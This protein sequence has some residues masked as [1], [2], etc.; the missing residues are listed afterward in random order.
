MIDPIAVQLGPVSIRWYAVCIMLGV[1]IAVYLAC[2]EAPR[3]GLSIDDIIDAVLWAFPIALIGARLYY[4]IF[5]WKHYQHNIE[6]IFAIWNG[7]IAIYGGLIAGWLVLYVFA[8]RRHIN[9]WDLTDIAVPGVLIAQAIGRWGNFFNQE[10]YGRAVDHLKLLPDWMQK[11]M[12]IDGSYRE[13]TFLYESSWNLVGF[14]LIMSVRHKKKC[15]RQGEI[16]LCYLIWYGL[17]RFV[18]EGFR[19]DSLYFMGVRVSQWLSLVLVAIGVS[20]MAY[21]RMKHE[22]PDYA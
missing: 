20:L 10:A 2:K 5:E 22:L 9:L 11:Q 1:G 3:K 7:G 4:V 18:I 15:F 12:W 16:T 21:R 6:S 8:R 19:S 13:P 14:I 17:G